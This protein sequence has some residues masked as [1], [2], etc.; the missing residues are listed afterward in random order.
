MFNE[1]FA[2]TKKHRKLVIVIRYWLL[3]AFHHS[4]PWNCHHEISIKDK[5]VK[6]IGKFHLWAGVTSF[7][8]VG[9]VLPFRIHFARRIPEAGAAG[10]TVAHRKHIDSDLAKHRWFVNRT[11]FWRW[12]V[13]IL[14]R[15]DANLENKFS[16][17]RSSLRN[18]S[19]ILVR[20]NFGKKVLFKSNQRKLLDT[21]CKEF[22]SE[23]H[24]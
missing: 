8:Q 6:L 7:Q 18:G 16:K 12:H 14:E 21:L 23:N 3:F 20:Q 22:G 5:T 17:S 15:G 19:P 24:H 4:A 13:H 1:L 11:G 9:S 2:H 10:W